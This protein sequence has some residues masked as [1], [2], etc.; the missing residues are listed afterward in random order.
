M[1][2]GLCL[3]GGVG[4]GGGVGCFM[5]SLVLAD[6]TT[7]PRVHAMAVAV[8]RGGGAAREGLGWGVGGGLW[9]GPP[10]NFSY[11][12]QGWRGGGGLRMHAT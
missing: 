10:I 9:E 11:K 2:L 12:S 7:Q 5:P 1:G 3:G 6:G 8:T 4:R